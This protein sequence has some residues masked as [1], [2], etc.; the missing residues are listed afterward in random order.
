MFVTS[1]TF[2]GNLGGL[3][4]AD[5]TCA[6]AASAAGLPGTFV[7]WL[8]TSSVDAISR[9]GTARGWVRA[10][11][12]PFVDT[13][14]D[15][16][17]GLIFYPPQVDEFGGYVFDAWIDTMTGTLADGTRASA[18]C[19]DWTSSATSDTGSVGFGITGAA[20]WTDTIDNAYTVPGCM[21]G[22]HLYC[23]QV[24]KQIPVTVP[25]PTTR[26]AFV[27]TTLIAA[28]GGLSAGD[29]ACA[30]DAAAAKL[31]GTYLAM[32]GTS[33]MTA[34]SRFSL[35]GSTWSRVD[36]ALLWNYAKD[37][38]LIDP[39]TPITLQADG[40]VYTGDGWVG[41][42]N[43]LSELGPWSCNDWSSSSS[44]DTGMTGNA[45]YA[46]WW[47]YQAD[48]CDVMRPVFCF[49]E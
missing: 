38:A 49:E 32:M 35:T 42:G 30:K 45:T 11:G 39:I 1:A 34:T 43:S 17:A 24:D 5:A 25:A 37:I 7:A 44:T 47:L 14:A 9:L 29:A 26:L 36:G 19:S 2:T 28:T 3:T 31:S 15:M 12:Q 41:S 13:T 8:S 21:G 40:S 18:T 6:T 27:S 33:T 48:S 10:D 4:G 46:Q 23:F 22:E 20:S 16:V